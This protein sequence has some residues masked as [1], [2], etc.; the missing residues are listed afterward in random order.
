L[1]RNQSLQSN[2]ATNVVM[3][4]WFVKSDLCY[5]S[6]KLYIWAGLLDT[7]KLFDCRPGSACVP[8]A[9]ERADVPI[10]ILED[11]LLRS[12]EKNIIY[13]QVYWDGCLLIEQLTIFDS[14]YPL[15]TTYF[16]LF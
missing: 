4:E 8:S 12:T 9:R 15:L 1:L 10:G 6:S 7:R 3:G 14:Y 16:L 2:S 5:F 13:G 11:V